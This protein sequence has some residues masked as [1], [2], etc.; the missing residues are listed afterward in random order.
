MPNKRDPIAVNVSA[1]V[2]EAVR[3]AAAAD[4]RSM[5]SFVGLVLLEFLQ[6]KGLLPQPKKATK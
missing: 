3:K 2:K 1:E 4:H 6:R 5:G